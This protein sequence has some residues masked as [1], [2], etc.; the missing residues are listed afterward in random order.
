MQHQGGDFWNQNDL[1]L[2]RNDRESKRSFFDM[3]SEICC[4]FANLL[5]I[6]KFV[7]NLP[8]EIKSQK[9]KSSLQ[10]AFTFV[11]RMS[12]LAMAQLCSVMQSSDN[13]L[14]CLGQ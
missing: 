8:I 11:M 3:A 1:F 4:K 14:D 2:S 6:C 9:S 10:F 12:W 5:Q 13:G 7:S